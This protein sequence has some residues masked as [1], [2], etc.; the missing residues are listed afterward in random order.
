[1]L[2]VRMGENELLKTI[3]VETK[4]VQGGEK[5]ESFSAFCSGEGNVK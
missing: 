1:M 4:D 2:C 5:N 3:V